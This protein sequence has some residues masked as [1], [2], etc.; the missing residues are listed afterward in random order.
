MEAAKMAL[1]RMLFKTAMKQ[2]IEQYGDKNF[3]VRKLE[4]IYNTVRHLTPQQCRDVV[5][6]I[7]GSCKYAPTVD[8]FRELAKVYQVEHVRMPCNTCGG[9]GVVSV[10]LK[11]TGHSYAFA[12]SCANGA[13]YPAWANWGTVNQN[14]YTRLSPDLVVQIPDDKR[15]PYCPIKLKKFSELMQQV[16]DGKDGEAE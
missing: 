12:C 14:L 9:G 4:L 11:S 6:K 1:D 15:K 2:L 8:D 5:D 7:I 13:R 16:L 10:W 3:G